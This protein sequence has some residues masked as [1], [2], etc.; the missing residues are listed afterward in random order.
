MINQSLFCLVFTRL[1]YATLTVS[2]SRLPSNII[3]LC[4]EINSVADEN[5]VKVILLIFA[6][7]KLQCKHV[8]KYIII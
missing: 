8:D 3:I 7:V 6:E 5:S 4:F 1:R 2:H